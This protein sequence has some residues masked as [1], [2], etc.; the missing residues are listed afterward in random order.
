LSVNITF[1]ERIADGFY[2]AKSVR[3]LRF[4]LEHPEYLEQP[5]SAPVPVDVD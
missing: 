4:L 1:D 3:I 2:F 5:V